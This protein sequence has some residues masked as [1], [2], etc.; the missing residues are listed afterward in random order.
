M[1]ESQSS[2]KTPPELQGSSNY[3]YWANFMDAYLATKGIET[4]LAAWSATDATAASAAAWAREQKKGVAYLI[5]ASSMDAMA[6]IQGKT[7]VKAAFEALELEY[8]G[9]GGLYIS[10]VKSQR[11]A[12]RIHDIEGI[13]PGLSTLQNLNAEL[14]RLGQPQS[15][16]D[17]FDALIRALSGSERFQ[18]LILSTTSTTAHTDTSYTTFVHSL[19]RLARTLVIAESSPRAFSAQQQSSP[20]PRSSSNTLTITC[21]N[22][23]RRGHG[24][25]T[26]WREGGGQAGQGPR[27][28]AGN[29]QRQGREQRNGG[30]NG[31]GGGNRMSEADL[32]ELARRVAR[33]QAGRGGGGGGG[34]RARVARDV[35]EQ[36]Q[37]QD[38]NDSEDSNY[39]SRGRGR[40]STSISW[41][42]PSAEA[43]IARPAPIKL[44][45]DS[46]ATDHH[47]RA[48]PLSC[49]K[50]SAPKSIGLAGEGLSIPSLG[51]GKLPLRTE[52]SQI[53]L[54]NVHHTPTIS[55][56]LLSV[57]RLAREGYSVIL[58]DNKGAIVE[59]AVA[60]PL[61]GRGIGLKREGEGWILEGKV[62]SD[63]VYR[64]GSEKRTLVQWHRAFAHLGRAAIL[65][66]ARLGLR[67]GF[68]LANI[69]DPSSTILCDACMEGKSH[70]QPFPKSG[71]SRA[72]VPL[73][74]VHG[75]LAGPFST[76]AL[77]GYHYYFVLVDDASRYVWIRLLRRKSEALE[78]FGVWH[79]EVEKSVE[80]KLKEFHSDRGGEFVSGRFQQY[81]EE[82][83][84]VHRTTQARSPEQN[85]V[86]E[87]MNR[88][89]KEAALT[90]LRDG[91]LP[92]ST[93]S[94]AVLEAARSRNRSPT[95]ALEATTPFEV[96]RGRKPKLVSEHPLGCRAWKHTA[97]E[98]RSRAVTAPKA[99]KGRF[100]GHGDRS[101]GFKIL[102]DDSRTVV[103][104][105]DVVF[106]DDD[107]S[108][109][110][111]SIDNDL[112]ADDLLPTPSNPAHSFQLP[113]IDDD[114]EE[115]DSPEPQPTPPPAPAPNHAPAAAP[116]PRRAAPAPRRTA[117]PPPP[118]S[119]GLRYPL[120]S[121][122]PRYPT[123]KSQ[124]KAA[125]TEKR[126]E[127]DPKSW[128]EAMTGSN[129]EEWREAARLELES[130]GIAGVWE[131]VP[132]RAGMKVVGSRWV[133]KVKKGLA[134][135]PDVFKARFVAQGFLQR[136]GRD[137][138]ETYA[139]T[140]THSAFRLLM[141]LA[142]T[143][144]L[145]LVQMDFKSAFLNGELEHEV[146][147]ELPEG[148]GKGGGN[149]AHLKKALYGLK[150]AGRAW[151][152]KLHRTLVS[153]GFEQVK[154][155]PSLFTYRSED[156]IILLLAH[157]DDLI[158][159]KSGPAWDRIKR[160]LKASF[161]MTG[162][163]EPEVALG[164][165]VQRD[166]EAGT[167][168][169][170]SPHYVDDLLLEHGMEACNPVKTPMQEGLHLTKLDPTLLPSTGSKST[171]QSIVGSL[172]WLATTTRPDLSA[173][174]GILA[175]FS[176]DP[177]ES[178]FKAA[179][180]VLRYLR[181]T[182]NWGVQFG[183][184]VVNEE[185]GRGRNETFVFAD[186][187]WGNDLDDS[188]SRTGF[189]AMRNGPISWGSR[190]QA[191]V[192]LS[193][194]EA[195]LYAYTEAA[196]EAMHQ[197]MLL[198]AW[199]EPQD[200]PTVILGDNQGAERLA[201]NPVF[202]ARSK[203]IRIRDR[204]VAEKVAEGECALVHVPTALNTSDI[205][206]KPLGRFKHVDFRRRLGMAELRS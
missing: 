141:S 71:A 171:Y 70:R 146:Y 1:S 58:S 67:E 205:L 83:G 106:W 179:K 120:R 164:I 95:K 87:R 75:D 18:P 69:I 33:I 91:Q 143:G 137:Y 177:R 184:D 172:M 162:G 111:S 193:T 173:V 49:T 132:R 4:D 97:K 23:N 27:G 153:L 55:E 8:G 84:I 50:F 73:A 189:V 86:A 148:F 31:G 192:A 149:V 85:G 103:D 122:A 133:F 201:K 102:L 19:R 74:L 129:S 82:H 63:V 163:G 136:P 127:R 9:G 3:R 156:S 197:R 182:R 57:H 185:V 124:A 188:R 10:D 166:R 118:A 52:S 203:H 29:G 198:A 145:D 125:A 22:C 147:I 41:R 24:K 206:T 38:G 128:K 21:T 37:E 180:H 68:S 17:K 126:K 150:Q 79:R 6:V 187:D 159:A 202:H 15:A 186:A 61:L 157:V 169:L 45:V 109:T 46:G 92:P 123:R 155:Q 60:E 131:E 81:L 72:D 140:P 34:A 105:R 130:I 178:H 100:L 64:V 144:S 32:D 170:G 30:R 12:V 42:K 94:Y 98:D 51:A 165:E 101:K 43:R 5:T 194:T 175:Q 176:S 48:R 62:V 53:I 115:D 117:P 114:E 76:E 204:F 110:S 112:L 16:A 174:V 78:A 99:I 77:G 181:G 161:R 44:L 36:E 152:E 59:K 25:E 168:T 35:D 183:G 89:I 196:K 158:A 134:G 191:V 7:T 195:E 190:K 160:E 13:E 56:N 199:G 154:A 26:C 66:M 80:R 107:F 116:A 138:E 200:R 88:T 113:S 11:E 28:R 14:A 108:A 142:A 54:N 135:K 139:H 2:T 47:S 40:S 96:L 119:A 39:F 90:M 93:W 167:I 65:E 121:A 104:S 20:K 151:S